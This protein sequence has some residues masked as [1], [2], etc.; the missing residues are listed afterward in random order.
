MQSAGMSKLSTLVYRTAIAGSCASACSAAV[1]S[2]FG[3]REAHSAVAPINAVSH[4]YWGKE[5]LSRQGFDVSH[6]VVG[7]ATHHI[8]ALF[9]AGLLCL[10]LQRAPHMET[11][12]RLLGA[13]AATSAIACFVDYKLTPERLTP[14]YEHRV[15]VRALSVTYI[16]FAAGLAIGTIA[17]LLGRRSKRG[18]K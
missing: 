2:H 16:A 5:A 8:A 18:A 9:W 10:Y 15:S 6:T 12:R 13:S 11:P 14:G 4:W 7:Y 3:R 1:L 17:T